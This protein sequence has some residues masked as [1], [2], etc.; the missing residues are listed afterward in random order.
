MSRSESVT[1]R[2]TLA[3]YEAGVDRYVDALAPRPIGPFVDYRERFVA[4]LPAGAELLELGS[5]PGLDAD[6]FSSRGFDVRR[7][8]ATVAFVERLRERGHA[9]DVLDVITDELGGPYDG[10]WASAVLLHL[11]RA[12]LAA[13]LVKLRAALSPDGVFG[14]TVKEGDGERW[15]TDKLDDPRY[16]VYW[17]SEP[18]ADLLEATGWHIIE[19]SQQPGRADD[20]LMVRARP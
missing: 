13:V 16:F 8:D 1:N 5:G 3:A 15:T 7:T 14:F 6:W 18:L 9:A 10:I 12:E 2:Q 17:R 19:L 11:S 20:W 4:D